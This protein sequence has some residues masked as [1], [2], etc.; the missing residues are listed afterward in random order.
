MACQQAAAFHLLA[1]QKEVHSTW[2]TP[3]SLSELKRKEYLGLKDPQLTWDY[4][5]ET[6]M[7]AIIL[8]W[9]AIWAKD[10]PDMF[11]GAVQELHR[12]LALVVEEGNWIN[13]EEE[14]W[15]GVMKDPVVAAAPRAPRPQSITADA[16]IG[17][18]HGVYV[19]GTSIC[20]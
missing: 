15:E 6:A 20:I 18:A 13:M 11:Y 19:T 10:P 16:W 2:L 7:L 14:I 17:E 8:Q 12:H 1:A 3:S 5:E 9:C 4:Q